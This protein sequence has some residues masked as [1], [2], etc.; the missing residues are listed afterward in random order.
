M[1]ITKIA[2]PIISNSYTIFSA[3]VGITGAADK[4]I[5]ITD[6]ISTILAINIAFLLFLDI[7]YGLTSFGLSCL[8][9]IYERNNKTYGNNDVNA[10]IVTSTLYIASTDGS[11]VVVNNIILTIT[12]CSITA[13][14]GILCSLTFVNFSV[15]IPF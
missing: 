12:A 8:N 2:P 9:F 6:I 11:N 5:P 14:T 3:K 4:T 7:S 10:V 15:N 1:P 13:C